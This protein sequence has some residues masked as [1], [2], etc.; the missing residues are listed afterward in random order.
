MDK[1][2]GIA[3]L[4]FLAASAIKP[5]IILYIAKLTDADYFAN[6]VITRD[7]FTDFNI[8]GISHY[9]V[10]ST[11]TSMSGI[12]TMISA[13]K[14]KYNKKIMIVET[15]YPWTSQGTYSY[16]NIISGTTGFSGYG[17]SD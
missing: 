14:T 15:A 1:H 9:Y 3:A 4:D 16:A 10:Y 6:S 2:G 5:Q 7:G 13:L 17:V 12:S 8:P 11:L